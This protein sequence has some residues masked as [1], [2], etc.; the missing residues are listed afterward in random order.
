[1]LAELIDAVLGAETDAAFE[2][3]ARRYFAEVAGRE[4]ADAEIA[5]V[6]RGDL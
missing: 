5:A 3:A 6:M 2:A 1:M 4:P